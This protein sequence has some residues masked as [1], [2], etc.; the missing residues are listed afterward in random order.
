M[1]PRLKIIL[2]LLGVFVLGLVTGLWVLRGTAILMD[3]SNVGCF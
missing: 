1:T 3:Y 2:A